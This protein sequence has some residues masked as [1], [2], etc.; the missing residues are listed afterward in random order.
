MNT[1]T[2]FWLLWVG[3]VSLVAIG[4]AI[5]GWWIMES[6]GHDWRHLVLLGLVGGTFLFGV[7]LALLWAYLD[8]A[9][10]RPLDTVSRGLRIITQTNPAHTLELSTNHLLG[11]LPDAVHAFA[12][13]VQK[14]RGE[15]ARALATGAAQ[16]ER[17]KSWLEAVVQELD[18]G[19]LVCDSQARILLYNPA[20]LRILQN[21]PSLGLHRPLYNLCKRAPIEHALELLRSRSPAERGADRGE[22]KEA[23]FICSTGDGGL[24]LRCRIRLL[25]PELGIESGF[26]LAFEDVTRHIEAF[27]RRDNLLRRVLEELRPPLANVRAAAENLAGFPDMDVEARNSFHTVLVEETGK[28]SH[29]LERISEDSRALVGREWLMGDVYSADVVQSVIRRVAE[30]DGMVVTMTGL[31]LWIH[32]DSHS[33]MLSLEHL[34]R[35]LKEET[36]A[37]AFDIETLLGDRR[38]YFDVVWEGEPMPLSTLEVWLAEPL[39][40]A[41]GM[42]TVRDIIDVHGG[43][44]WSQAHRRAGFA[45]VRFPVPASSKQ[46]EMPRE[47]IPPRPEFYDFGLLG[48]PRDLGDLADRALSDLSYVV[49]DT[50]TTGLKPSEG[51]EIVSIAGVRIVNERIL[52][53]ETFERFVNPGRKIPK[54]STRFH[55]ITDNHV[56]EKPPIQVVLPQFKSF[57]GDSVLVAHNAAFDM[58]FIKLK[59]TE[60][61][62]QFDNPVLDSLLLSVFLHEHAEN[63][64]LDGIA[65]RLGVEIRG[66]HTALGDALV[67][68]EVFLCLVDLLQERGIKTLGQALEASAEMIE[69]RKLEATF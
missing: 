38:V 59:E 17:Q 32:A 39:P 19:V 3:V 64:T 25:S 1:R 62:V 2:R 69:R 56:K 63:H 29:V 11:D 34:L 50:E 21:S 18:E 58:K 23:E 54:A 43:D 40:D 5:F 22:A 41:V 6:V 68:S 4:M 8:S 44:A 57:V 61:G 55:G 46:W 48:Q 30:R 9:L 45:L 15:V 24:L 60:S 31:P 16:A 28:L 66:R 52:S 33:L 7:A 49:F 47:S 35:R 42:L 53:G 27:A 14:A 20:A 13:E 51:D 26:V 10:M 65:D 12:G 37:I 67:T 36:G